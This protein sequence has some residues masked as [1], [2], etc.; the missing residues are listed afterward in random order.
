MKEVRRPMM[1]AGTQAPTRRVALFID[2]D[3]VLILAQNSGLPFEL[4]LI[5][6]RARQQGTV[7][8]SKAYADWTANFLRP[9]LGDF[10]ANAIELVQLPTSN[11]SREH[12]NTADIQLTVD[13]LEMVFSPVRPE[14]M[15]IVGGD[16]DYVPL[17][18]KLKRYGV[19]VMGMGVEAG[20][21][22][23]LVEACD[24]FV[25][26]DDLV[27][28]PNEALG[29]AT[30]P[31]PLPDPAEA[32]ALMRRAVE[33]LSREGRV[34]TGASV[35]AMMRQLSPA[36]DIARYRQTMKELAL[37]AESAGFVRLTENPGTDFTLAVGAMPSAPTILRPQAVSRRYDFSTEASI[38]AS[39][40]AILQNQ[41]IPLLQWR[42]REEFLRLVWSYFD[43]RKPNGIHFDA[44]RENL[45]YHAEDHNLGVTH[46]MIQKLLYTLNFGRCF[47]Y[48]NN[49]ATGAVILIPQDLYVPIHAAVDAEEAV[50]R[51][52]RRYVEI[53]GRNAPVLHPGAAYDLLYGDEVDDEDEARERAKELERLCNSIKPVGGF[54]QAF[55]NSIP[56]RGAPPG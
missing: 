51:L 31:M 1:E 32:H 46:Q 50:R 9:V 56:Y 38:T 52:H 26:Y 23:V 24:S 49:A 25:F 4:S 34:A 8:S 42:I 55:L 35:N 3:N 37:S 43:E 14:T 33:A 19:F 39:Y 5:I 54:G 36:F 41:R 2:V 20:V 22:K 30:E 11:S 17:V 44:I 13:A 53:I 45:E 6:D 16:R 40:R 29:E 10:R 18:Q 7:M 12:K 21:S 15:V 47:A 48:G 28:P 27:P